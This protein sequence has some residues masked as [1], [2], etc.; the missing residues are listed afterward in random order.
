[1]CREGL[2]GEDGTCGGRGGRGG[3]G[4]GRRGCDM[5]VV[6]LGVYGAVCCEAAEESVGGRASDVSRGGTRTLAADTAN[7]F[8][9]VFRK[10]IH[11]SERCFG[12]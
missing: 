11:F 3:C 7:G 1:M 4:V 6:I 8:G 9:K 5:T 12:G 10:E 2:V